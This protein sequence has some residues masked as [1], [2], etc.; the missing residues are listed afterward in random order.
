MTSAIGREG[1]GSG[2][3]HLQSK[4]E[5]GGA[6][7]GVEALLW[8]E[9]V[10][11]RE[12]GEKDLIG[13][14]RD[15][16]ILN[17]E[18]RMTGFEVGNWRPLGRKEKEALELLV[19]GKHSVDGGVEG[20]QT[21]AVEVIREVAELLS[22]LQQQ[23]KQLLQE[24][25]TALRVGG[26]GEEQQ[27]VIKEKFQKEVKW[28]CLL[29]AFI[30]GIALL[31][32]LGYDYFYELLRSHYPAVDAEM[33]SREAFESI[34]SKY[35]CDRIEIYLPYHSGVLLEIM[36]SRLSGRVE[37]LEIVVRES[38][39]EGGSSET[40]YQMALTLASGEG[41]PLRLLLI[42]KLVKQG[43]SHPQEPD[44]LFRLRYDLERQWRVQSCL[45][46]QK[47]G[48]LV[49]A[50]LTHNF[51][52][53]RVHDWIDMLQLWRL[54]VSG[55][56]VCGGESMGEKL[57]KLGRSHGLHLGGGKYSFEKRQMVFLQELLAQELKARIGA[58]EAVEAVALGLQVCFFVVERMPANR[59][60][61][62]WKEI[63]GCYRDL[64]IP[65]GH[66]SEKIISC[67][68]GGAITLE[69]VAAH[70]AV[71]ALMK[72]GSDQSSSESVVDYR[73][74]SWVVRWRC[75]EV[76]LTL[77]WSMNWVEVL[78]HYW[79][80][81]GE[82]RE[83]L[84]MLIKELLGEG[85]PTLQVGRR[86][87]WEELWHGK[88]WGELL[89]VL[90]ESRDAEAE[91]C[92]WFLTS[93]LFRWGSEEVAPLLKELLWQRIFSG[94]EQRQMIEAA[95]TL[96]GTIAEKREQYR[97]LAM[98]LQS[99]VEAYSREGVY[100]VA[101]ELLE[102]K[103]S[104]LDSFYRAYVKAPEVTTF[105]EV[106]EAVKIA[107]LWSSSDPQKVLKSL[108][109]WF[110]EKKL[111]GRRIL[112]LAS[113]T[114][115]SSSAAML[116]V[117]VMAI[118]QLFVEGLKQLDG[119]IAVSQ[120]ESVSSCCKL[121]ME[122]GYHEEALHLKLL[123]RGIGYR[124]EEQQL[125][126]E[127]LCRALESL[128]VIT[129]ELSAPQKDLYSR[130][131]VDLGVVKD[132]RDDDEKGVNL[133]LIDM[134]CDIVGHPEFEKVSGYLQQLCDA[135]KK[136]PE[137]RYPL[138]KMLKTL[139]HPSYLFYLH[140]RYSESE[141]FQE[142]S[143][144]FS[145]VVEIAEEVWKDEE[146]REEV[147]ALMPFVLEEYYKALGAE[148]IF[149]TLSFL[150][151]RWREASMISG[152]V[153]LLIEMPSWQIEKNDLLLQDA[154]WYLALEKMV[155]L[156][157]DVSWQ[158]SC[159][160]YVKGNKKNILLLNFLKAVLPVA[161]EKGRWRPLLQ[162]RLL[163]KKNLE[164]RSVF[165]EVIVFD[166]KVID[167]CLNVAE[168]GGEDWQKVENA[169]RDFLLHLYEGYPRIWHTEMKRFVLLNI[170]HLLLTNEQEGRKKI[171][172]LMNYLYIFED[173]RKD[174]LFE[175]IIRSTKLEP[176]EVMEM[177]KEF[178]TSL[179]SSRH[180][181]QHLFPVV[182]SVQ[183][184][185]WNPEGEDSISRL[186][187]S[188]E[189]IVNEQRLRDKFKDF[190][191]R[192]L[193]KVMT[194][195]QEKESGDVMSKTD[196]LVASYSLKYLDN[197]KYNLC[198]TELLTIYEWLDKNITERFVKHE[199]SS[200]AEYCKLNVARQ[201]LARSRGLWRQRKGSVIEACM[202]AVELLNK[203][204]RKRMD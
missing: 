74:R 108:K 159:Q 5:S 20:W 201:I 162:C 29:G 135:M 36:R 37:G 56:K 115:S 131:L 60:E 113:T 175:Q 127:E 44:F 198:R 200:S 39:N 3:W 98:D 177:V 150:L 112:E 137:H 78:T 165:S 203:W 88:E 104:L 94:G 54:Q 155:A 160:E 34:V 179:R 153:E 192:M 140:H 174:E 195:R 102:R 76:T 13:K 114:M 57:L 97:E 163:W 23:E 181:Q 189:I 42:E 55:M 145:N 58:G 178:I 15:A 116:A 75:G 61:E 43:M 41:V 183:R 21:S 139:V 157:E 50:A 92:C 82:G 142:M 99:S 31:R 133:E 166:R 107:S 91:R 110:G 197:Y 111:V 100:G 149:K 14:L 22:E 93:Y 141:R 96:L 119:E 66:L 188:E 7:N 143:H 18:G 123:M 24:R 168:K 83:P 80:S 118:Y 187:W 186:I 121:L 47:I 30:G 164:D 51:E 25:E 87:G 70:M 19:K 48:D 53:Y 161:V 6:V 69:V 158:K 27:Q 95:A 40:F 59:G 67:V 156:L 182:D 2:E 9:K 124:L 204:L 109:P 11:D 52:G 79:K 194:Y 35:R 190:F 106:E 10:E 71:L 169:L 180:F 49:I 126:P 28:G 125:E 202:D 147:Q 86:E 196:Y 117:G 191:L 8:E 134:A 89:S 85:E 46:H 122:C 12:E 128:A 73:E 120:R 62:L 26:M 64:E 101:L 176:S 90:S 77:Q 185:L 173:S 154:A 129:E 68:R 136:A 105:I 45:V 130:P 38:K 16:G 1:S 144:H 199:L 63:E 148:E 171:R 103:S 138:Q 152:L 151:R 17:N 172:F 193:N 4:K 170:N 167:L 81:E 72:V 32:H 132:W 184:Y 65:E 33:I 146:Y 84:L